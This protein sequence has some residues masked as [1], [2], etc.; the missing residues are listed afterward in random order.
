MMTTSHDAAARRDITLPDRLLGPEEVAAYL[1]VPLR[2]IYRWRSRHEGPH[3]YRV[4][5]HVR[6]RRDDVDRWLAS[7]RDAS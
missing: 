2:T 5:R 6:Y 1:G 4:G 7:R 3:G